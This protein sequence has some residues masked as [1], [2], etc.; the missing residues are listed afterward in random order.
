MKYSWLLAVLDD[1]H[2]FGTENKILNF[3]H[4]IE[5][6]KDTILSEIEAER[7]CLQEEQK[8]EAGLGILIQVDFSR[9]A[10]V[11]N[12]GQKWNVDLERLSR[13]HR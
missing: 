3:L 12:M 10:G 2:D 9:M 4:F 11:S 5:S 7:K 1:I 8:A 6:A 13:L